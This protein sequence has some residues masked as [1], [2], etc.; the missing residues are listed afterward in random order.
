MSSSMIDLAPGRGEAGSRNSRISHVLGMGMGM[1]MGP[2][3]EGAHPY[4]SQ[5]HLVYGEGL[6]DRHEWRHTVYLVEFLMRTG[7]QS[8]IELPDPPAEHSGQTQRELQDLRIKR[9]H[10]GRR[11]RADE[12]IA[13]I[14][15]YIGPY[16]NLCEFDAHSHPLTSSLVRIVDLIGW[17][18][19]Q[20]YKEVFGRRRPS[21]LDPS[22]RP[23]VRVPT[24]SS[25]P[26]GH[27]AQ[28]QLI[29]CALKKVLSDRIGV[30]SPNEPQVT[31]ADELDR[32]TQRIAEN[33]E[34]AGVHFRSDT[35]AG[36]LLAVGA[37]RLMERNGNFKK[38]IEAAKGEW[39]ADHALQSG[40]RFLDHP[41]RKKA[42]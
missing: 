5:I 22:I 37:W 3:D 21:Q 18:L 20:Y 31:L 35:E 23:M 8:E 38:L 10:E 29:G 7:W 32:I 4:R 36:K 26:G 11:E 30:P 17:T 40:Y 34:W 24:F 9:D 13:E 39:E 15:D 41:E 6:I 1:G 2:N 19:V 25:Y 12:I 28:A 16:E 42:G 33:R 27:A 14:F